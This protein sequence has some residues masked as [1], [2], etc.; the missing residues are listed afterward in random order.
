MPSNIRI[1]IVPIPITL[2]PLLFPS[3]TI[4]WSDSSSIS[5]TGTPIYKLKKINTVSGNKYY[6]IEKKKKSIQLPTTFNKKN[7]V[8]RVIIF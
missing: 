6:K 8:N 5:N 7:S 3:S 4:S 1:L 2:Q